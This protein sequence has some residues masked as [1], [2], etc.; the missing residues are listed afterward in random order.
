MSAICI[1]IWPSLEFLDSICTFYFATLVVGCTIPIILE[2]VSMLMEGAPMDIN[3][4]QLL[5]DLV[6]VYDKVGSRSKE[7]ARFTHMVDFKR[8]D[9]THSASGVIMPV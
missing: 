2:H 6:N 4:N 9:C 8:E 3:I 1:F 5:K 7:S